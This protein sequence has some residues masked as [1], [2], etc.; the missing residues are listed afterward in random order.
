MLRKSQY[1]GFFP[2]SKLDTQRG[3]A[4]AGHRKEDSEEDEVYGG[5]HQVGNK[6]LLHS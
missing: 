1:F 4:S 3:Y 6:G 5:P 2:L